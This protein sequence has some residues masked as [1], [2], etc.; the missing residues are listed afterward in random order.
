LSKFVSVQ[1]PYSLL[2]R[3]YEIGMS[4]IAKYEGVG[5]LAYSPLAFGY[6]TGKF[7]NGARPANARVTLF[8]RFSR[9]S[10]PE[11]EWATEQYA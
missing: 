2:N 9:Y 1:N 11:S 4:E 3:T 5:L 10:N 6:L 8:S 7:R